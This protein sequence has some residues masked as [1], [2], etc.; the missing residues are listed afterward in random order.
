MNVEWISMALLSTCEKGMLI[1]IC[2]L[3]NLSKYGLVNNKKMI[4]ARLIVEQVAASSRK[5]MV[6][7][8]SEFRNHK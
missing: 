7:W 3:G 8:K 2:I 5:P 4:R 1:N 6:Q